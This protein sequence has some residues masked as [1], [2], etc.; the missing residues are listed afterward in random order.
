MDDLVLSKLS[1]D[2]LAALNDDQKAIFCLLSEA[3]Q[4]FF[5]QTFKPADLPVALERKGEILK[6][7]QANREFME[8]FKAA[9]QTAA[10]TEAP[11][12][13]ESGAAQDAKPKSSTSGEDILTAVAGAVG[14]GAAAAAVASDNS[15][16]WRGVKPNDLVVPLRNEF[17]NDRTRVDVAGNPQALTVSVMIL[18][19]GHSVPALTIGLAQENDSTTVKMSDL[20]TH[21]VLE[22]VKEGGMKILGMAADGLRIL[23]HSKLGGISPDE[24]VN[25][26]S[27]TFEEGADLAEVAGN[28]KLKDRAWKVVKQ[29]AE[30]VEASYLSQLEQE[31]QARYALEKAWDNYYNCLTCGVPFGAE[32]ANCRVCGSARPESPKKMDPRKQ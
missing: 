28:L 27:H 25:T 23:T 24:L 11:A 16:S 32:D 14:L 18:S 12:E 7:N 21:G 3:D 4:K 5:S 30:T 2:Q 17:N 1:A 13:G 31:R 6:R 8:R 9:V 20:T 15:A 10:P 22:T 29:T 26:A 19:G